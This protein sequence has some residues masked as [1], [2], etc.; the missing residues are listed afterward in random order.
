MQDQESQRTLKNELNHFLGGLFF[1][2]SFFLPTALK[3]STFFFKRGMGRNI[4]VCSRLPLGNPHFKVLS[5]SF[6]Q[7]YFEVNCALCTRTSRNFASFRF[8]FA[9]LAQSVYYFSSSSSP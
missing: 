2:S 8:D 6:I 5:S 1:F 3:D 7:F 4:A 9:L